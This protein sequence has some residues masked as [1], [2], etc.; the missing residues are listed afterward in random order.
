MKKH[1]PLLY[2]S[3]AVLTTLVAADSVARKRRERIGDRA[4]REWDGSDHPPK[5]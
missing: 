4:P 3:L 2:I 1:C 5:S